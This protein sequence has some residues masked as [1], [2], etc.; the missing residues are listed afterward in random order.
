MQQHQDSL[1]TKYGTWT[2]GDPWV[3]PGPDG[4]GAT[5]RPNAA[6]STS[7][8]PDRPRAAAAAPGGRGRLHRL[9]YATAS[10]EIE[11]RRRAFPASGGL[12]ARRWPT[13]SRKPVIGSA[14][15]LYPIAAQPMEERT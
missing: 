10:E 3:G 11:V 9:I 6:P 13:A 7:T 5:C 12:N 2:L 14:L 15:H 4:N 1:V 8:A